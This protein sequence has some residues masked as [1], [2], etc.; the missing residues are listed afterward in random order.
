M[1][2][3]A[4]P[5]T[6][7]TQVYTRTRKVHWLPKKYTRRVL[8]LLGSKARSNQYRT[9]RKKVHSLKV[10]GLMLFGSHVA[11]SGLGRAS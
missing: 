1:T 6:W 5:G 2:I 3:V 4:K 9:C 10:I 8:F 7:A 11:S